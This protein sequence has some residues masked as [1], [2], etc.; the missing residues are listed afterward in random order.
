MGNTIDGVLKPTMDI[1]S[2]GCVIAELFMEGQTLF[3]LSQL[4]A[5]RRGQYD[6]CPSLQK[7]KD[8]DIREMILHMIQLDP[9]AR[10]SAEQYLQFRAPRVFPVYFSSLLHSFFSYILPYDVDTRVAI[11]QSAFPELCKQMIES[12]CHAH[13]NKTG[14]SVSE[15]QDN[16]E[17]REKVETE[18]HLHVSNVDIT[19]KRRL[20]AAAI[21][22]GKASSRLGQHPLAADG[23]HRRDISE[24]IKVL[25]TEG[26]FSQGL[27]R[28]K[29]KCEGVVLIASLLCA[30]IRNVKFPQARRGALQML[31]K[32]CLYID[33]EVRL[34]HV[35]PFVV[36][37]LSDGAA[38][39]RCA[40]LQVVCNLLSLIEN[41]PRSDSKIFPEY[42]L[43]L[44]SM[45][46]EDPEECVR[47]CYADNIHMIAET[48]RRFL[49]SS[50]NIPDVGVLDKSVQSM[51]GATKKV[52]APT[53][54]NQ[55]G[56]RYMF[57]LSQLRE[58]IARVIQELVMG[59]KQTPAIRRALL[60][61]VKD[62]CN[63]FGT[64][65]CNDVLLP[66][67]PAFLNDRDEQLR[68]VF[69]EQI[70]YVSLF[71][72]QTSVESYLLPYIEQALSDVEETVIVNALECLA[73]ICVHRL[74]R[75]RVLLRAVER[76]SP[77]LCH[78]SQW[79]RKSALKVV[80]S[81]GASLGLV[82]SHAFLLPILSP[83]VRREP[84]ALDLESALSA[85]LKVPMSREMF[86]RVLSDAMLSQ[87]VPR[88]QD[89]KVDKNKQKEAVTNS[90]IQS[91]T[92]SMKTFAEQQ[93][94]GSVN[95]NLQ[96]A[97][98]L[99]PVLQGER[100]I[101]TEIDDNEKMKAMEGYIRD[102]SS[103]MQSR[104]LNWEVDNSEKLQ[105][106]IIG[107][108]AGAGTGFYSNYD[109]SSDGI[110]LYFLPLNEKRGDNQTSF[111][112]NEDWNR[113]VNGRHGTHPSHIAA[114]SGTPN[115]LA[116]RTIHWTEGTSTIHNSHV[117]Q[118]IMG[119]RF[120]TGAHHV[121]E[122][123]KDMDGGETDREYT[124][125]LTASLLRDNVLP[126]V[127]F[128]GAAESSGTGVARLAEGNS[129]QN[130][131]SSFNDNHWQPRGVLIA[132]LQEHRRA[133]NKVAV[134][135]DN[136]F[137]VSASDDGTVKLWD[138]KRLE[139]NI[140]FRSR[141]TYS[142]NDAKAV[143]VCMIGNG[144]QVAASSSSGKIHVLKV[145]QVS[146]TTSGIE[147]Y[148]GLTDV[149]NVDAQEG[150]VISLLSYIPDG[151][152]MLLYTTQR[153]GIRL[154][155]IR[156][157]KD[158]WCLRAKPSQGYISA[159]ALASC[160]TWL[161]TGTSR[162]VLTLWDL[163]FQIPVNTWQHPSGSFVE[164]MSAVL[165]PSES[166]TVSASRAYVYVAAGREEV[167]LWNAEDG[168]CQQV[169]R[170]GCDPAD[171]EYTEIPSA[172]SRRKTS[173]TADSK[174][175]EGSKKSDYKLEELNEPSSR[176]PGVR[177]LLPLSGG[178]GLIT[179][180]TDCK[181]RIWDRLRPERCYCVCGPSPKTQAIPS[182]YK[183]DSRVI[184]GMK[185]VQET[186][187]QQQ[188]NQTSPNSKGILTAAATDTAG[189]HRDSILSLAAAQTAQQNLLISS[190][191]D[192]SIKVW[193]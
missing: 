56:S 148:S 70:V 85:C 102:L 160:Y 147:R 115:I 119:S 154:W 129:V 51:R 143:C 156:L 188:K 22:M 141:V 130:S 145:D 170:L 33:D 84:V 125:G 139:S 98:L 187:S 179:G 87:P 176:I 46:P 100:L 163:R 72:G 121:Y 178:T 132:H 135:H 64:R 79:V 1:F 123:A 71:V 190:S 67:L 185:V 152:P 52:V 134:S 89:N 192:G 186:Y 83:F 13:K 21:V 57:E 8:K 109:G 19:P 34:Q 63:F 162:G 43:P 65:Q 3:D 26:C 164:T 54:L 91:N 30:S 11:T 181:I 99:S 94:T 27:M 169:L 157:E 133:V 41:F 172:L 142:F 193:R 12:S 165:P 182:V 61:H 107:M 35:L 81:V 60:Y 153:N 161:V 128:Q 96:S 40:A 151:P 175:I 93:K 50:Y 36:T 66:I 6:P 14:S 122:V 158:A 183:Y 131:S 44:L 104:M 189:C 28:N 110:P 118:A 45:L 59:P 42:I 17:D 117:Q 24:S 9:T 111:S 127:C 113:I 191:R 126:E 144:P 140:S 2:V 138:C 137:F 73:A 18:Q 124:K 120:L 112:F 167:A 103:T 31:Y 173:S 80:A 136:S 5:Y 97:A 146:K 32:A 177:A 78:P 69:F 174:R 74:L 88:K 92:S 25:Q 105:S 4:L 10:L 15:F 62:L 39:V 106:S 76:C 95:H 108:N 82:D 116:T 48:A 7:V 49:E 23:I 171:S 149:K 29:V 20:K 68:A 184:L 47:I 86:N 75:K 55:N 168:T 159:T 38:I 155:D 101:F 166:G 90:I 16:M 114:L 53:G 58:N 77:L 150:A 180:S 37:L